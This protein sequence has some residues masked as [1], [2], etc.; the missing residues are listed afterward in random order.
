MPSWPVVSIASS[1]LLT[2]SSVPKK[3]WLRWYY[4][5]FDLFIHVIAILQLELTLRWNHVRG[6]SALWTSVGQLIPFIIGVG[7]LGLVVSRFC[8]KIWVK[9]VTRKGGKSGWNVEDGKVEEGDVSV[10]GGMWKPGV[11][12]AYERWKKAHVAELEHRAV[13]AAAT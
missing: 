1:L 10:E 4:A 5:G 2:P 11:D 6:L 8:V 12:G 3:V 13:A 7:G 9:R